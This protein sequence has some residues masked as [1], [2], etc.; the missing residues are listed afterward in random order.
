VS[1]REAFWA[2]LREQ[3]GLLGDWGSGPVLQ[4][5][6]R[7]PGARWFAD[8]RLNYAENLLCGEPHATVLLF[9]DERGRRAHYTRAELR[10]RVA[11]VAAGLTGLGIGPGDVVAGFLPNVPEALIAMLA[12]ASL[13]AVWT[14]SSP[15]FGLDAVSERFGQV[16]AK[17]LVATDG[18]YYA[19]KAHDSLALVAALCERLPLLRQLLI[20]P[21]LGR[22]PDLASLPQGRLLTDMEHEQLQEREPRYR[23]MPFDAPLF[24]LYSSGTTGKPKC[25]VHGIGGSL[26]QHVKEH[27][28]HVDVRPADRLFY[29]TTCG[30][31]MWNWL[32]SALA[33]GAAI[34]LY[35]GSPLHPA[36]SV[37]WELAAEFRITQ[38]GTSPRYLASLQK[39]GYAPS[40]LHDLTAL[41]TLLSTGSPLSAEQFEFVYRDIKADLHLAS[42]SGGTDI[43]S[44]FCLGVPTL[45]V[46][47]G[48]LQAAGLGMAV[49]VWNEHGARVNGE[50]GDLVCTAAFPS[51][52]TGF[53]N[54][55]DGRRYHAAYFERFAG[56]WHHGDYAIETPQGGFVILGRSDATLN[57]GGVRIGTAEIYRQVEKLAEVLECV[58]IGQR[59]AGD[60]RI[61]LFVRLREGVALDLAL[62]R[63]IRETIRENTTPRHVPSRIL[64]VTDIPRTLSGK[65][66]E[67]AVRSAVN[68]LPIENLQALANPDALAQYRDRDELSS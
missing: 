32:A 49:E 14:S 61:V 33:S 23:R 64:A 47:R 52:P 5:A 21:C 45:P 51:M 3:S 40:A 46:Y 36:K 44:C 34:L 2:S 28:L 27:R 53:A 57:P 56:V 4:D 11:R 13:G 10:L 20:V 65:I 68:Q 48:Q 1:H 63:R 50:C 60:E 22:K 8:S 17:V 39:A 55:P 37:L 30:W 25:I 59:Q 43:L 35:D 15:D 18:H 26:L 66:V 29:F 16:G 67:L 19:G 42:I 9:A 54:D 62:Q 41:R 12:T 31:M 38:F 7:M 6:D 24:I 58:A